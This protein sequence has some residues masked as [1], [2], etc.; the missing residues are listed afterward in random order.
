MAWIHYR[1]LL[2][3]GV[4]LRFGFKEKDNSTKFW[5]KLMLVRGDSRQLWPVIKS[6]NRMKICLYTLKVSTPLRDGIAILF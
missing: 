5:G 3:S 6:A 1:F 2:H 4:E